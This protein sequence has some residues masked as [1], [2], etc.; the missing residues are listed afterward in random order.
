MIAMVE[1]DIFWAYA[2]GAGFAMAAAYQLVREARQGTSWWESRYF[3]VTLLFIALLFAPSGIYLLS[4]FP[5]WETMHVARTFDDLP[6]WLVTLF[7]ITNVTQGILG[8]WVTR[9]CIVKGHLTAAV[10]QVAL[11]YFGFFFILVNGWDATGY[12]R[13]LSAEH[14]VVPGWS[15]SDAGDWVTSPVAI[16]LVVMAV[17]IV[18]YAVGFLVSWLG[19]GHREAGG[20]PRLGFLKGRTALVAMPLVLIFG[21]GFLG[22]VA[23][24]LSIVVL[25]PAPGLALTAVGWVA[26]LHPRGPLAAIGSRLLGPLVEPEADLRDSLPP[27]P[28]ADRASAA[29]AGSL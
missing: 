3:V 12:K 23:S 15:W 1:V 10:A 2:F 21:F 11:S 27:E 18:P 8:Y 5:S 9:W 25:G 20:E 14:D 19:E 17:P 4:E 13:F 16:T 26:C 24:H 29:A 22:A 7:A 28:A 6:A